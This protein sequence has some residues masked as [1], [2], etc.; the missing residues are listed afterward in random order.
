MANL[1]ASLLLC[2]LDCLED[3]LLSGTHIRASA[4]HTAS[5]CNPCSP[6]PAPPNATSVPS[7]IWSFPKSLRFRSSQNF[8]EV[9]SGIGSSE[10]GWIL[11]G[12]SPQIVVFYRNSSCNSSWDAKV[13]NGQQTITLFPPFGVQS[14]DC[15]RSCEGTFQ[16][17]FKC[18][19]A[20]SIAIARLLGDLGGGVARG[21]SRHQLQ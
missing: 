13:R 11:Q 7:H 15:N 10:R 6:S 17:C 9:L 19:A 2:M 21:E 20:A 5:S 12:V 8:S 16:T 14:F 1:G 3:M 4:R 18:V